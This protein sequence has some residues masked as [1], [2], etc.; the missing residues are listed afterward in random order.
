MDSHANGT[1]NAI[2]GT[3]IPP[4]RSTTLLDLMVIVVENWRKLIVVP[5]LAGTIALG[6]SFALTPVYT[7]TARI[8]PPQQ[9]SGMSAIVASQLGA[10]AGL[11]G[12]TAGMKNPADQYVA[13]IRSRSVADRLIE[14]FGLKAVYE[15]TLPED[16][17]LEL[18]RNSTVTAG[19]DGLIV[20]DVDDPE[21]ARAAALANGYVAELRNMLRNLAIEESSQRRSFFETRL[22]DARDKLVRSEKLLRDSS[23]SLTVLKA[24]P[25]AAVE[26]VARMRAA[27]TVTELRIASMRGFLSESSPDLRQAKQELEALKSQLSQAVR[28]DGAEVGEGGEYIGRYRTFKYHETLYELL[29]KQY[30]MARLDEAREGSLVQVV[31][32]AVAPQRR[33]FPRRGLIATVTALTTG[34]LM[35]GAL[36]LIDAVRRQ[37]ADPAEAPKLARFAAAIGRTPSTRP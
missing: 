20:I 37:A 30:E 14:K 29:A 31:D 1:G 4:D 28:G 34:L 5:V 35:L 32:E 10:L 2:V 11:A 24:D 8:L 3:A 21:P 26:A 23:V 33:A 12:G 17:R 27:I 9:Q 36:F 16:A 22:A 13:M 15:A 6:I 18:A 19:K 25:R 7:A